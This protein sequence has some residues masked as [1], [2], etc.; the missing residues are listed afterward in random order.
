MWAA[1]DIGTNSCRLLI[2]QK[3]GSK[4][5]YEVERQLQMTRIGQG[6]ENNYKMISREAVERTLGAL[7]HYKSIIGRYKVQ[8]I[9]LVATQ[10]VREA[11]NKQELV[12]AVKEKLNLDV[13]IISG[14]RE[15]WLSYIGASQDLTVEKPLVVDIGGGSTELVS[16]D[17]SGSL[18][19]VSIPIGA[20][21]LKE[22]QVVP[23][24]LRELLTE[25]LE[26][27]DYWSQTAFSLV[28]VGGTCTTLGAVSLALRDYDSEKIQG[29]TL[30]K[31]AINKLY[32]KLYNLTPQQRLN[33][34]GIYPG[35][36]DII[37][38]GLEILLQLMDILKKEDL[39]ISDHDLLYGLIYETSSK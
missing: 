1:M 5:L 27:K 14:E 18:L 25:K 3:K 15:A 22:R 9:S 10:A 21:K 29:L 34:A 31:A 16:I 12:N 37:V 4:K 36:E 11:E 6:M 13:E 23:L 8:S 32:K 28:G 33:I 39:V 35:R 26:Q 38:T 17:T 20:L 30:S 2:T 19:A 24:K 7:Q